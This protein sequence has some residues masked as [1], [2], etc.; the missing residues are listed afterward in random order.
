[1]KVRLAEHFYS[2]QGEGKFAGHPALFIRFQ[3]CNLHCESD[4]WVCDTLEQMKHR[5]DFDLMDDVIQ[6]WDRF[7]KVNRIVFTGGEPM[8][9]QKQIVE[10]IKF[11]NDHNVYPAIEVETNGT[12]FISPELWGQG[13]QFNCSPKLSNSG[14]SKEMRYNRKVLNQIQGHTDSIFKFV[15]ASREDLEEMLTDFDWLFKYSREKI[16]LMPA[17]LSRNQQWLS[18]PEVAQIAMELGVKLA[19]RAHIM[20]WDTKKGV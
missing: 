2:I 6:S 9:Y 12:Q 1:M 4:K 10:I 11:F 5:Y 8:L 20:I 16:W 19:I 17:G 13:I 18:A 7:S 3:K 15:V 14:N